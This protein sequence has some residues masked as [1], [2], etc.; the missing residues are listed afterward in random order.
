MIN[1]KY[2]IVFLVMIP[3]LLINLSVS[4]LLGAANALEEMGTFEID[5]ATVV[6]TI[7]NDPSPTSPDAQ[8]EDSEQDQE[9]GQ[10][11]SSGDHS[12]LFFARPHLAIPYTPNIIEHHVT[13]PYQALPEVYL[14][15]FIPPKSHA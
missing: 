3:L 9:T 2:R 6:S 8:D 13:E 1:L 14:E 7:D 11:R 4:A 15:R 12:P 5:G 10:S